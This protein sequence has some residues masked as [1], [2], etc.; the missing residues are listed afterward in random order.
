[1]FVP[2]RQRTYDWDE[3]KS[4]YELGHSAAECQAR[5]AI[6]NGAWY[7]AVQ[8]GAIVLRDTRHRPRTRT[9]V[10]IAA[11]LAEGLSQAAIA[12]ELGISR[13]T[14]C[15]HL[16]KLGIAAAVAPARRY[17][18]DEI[19]KYYEAGHSAADCRARFGFSRDA[20]RDAVVR[21]AIEPRPKLEPI[22]EVLAAGRRRSRAHI[23]ARLFMAGL[24]EGCCEG[25][26]LTE[27]QG[28]P[29]ALELHHV[30]GDGRDNR[31]SNLQLLC[32][33]CHS[34]TDTWGGRNKARRDPGR[35]DKREAA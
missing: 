31:L 30:N 35:G 33:N 29:V 7:G 22:D 21:G 12:R 11:L 18:W 23:K 17:D 27:W 26:G 14:V 28:A 25:C 15:F 6:T 5:F 24:K 8:R 13:P 20:W 32:P 16:R 2:R 10:L 19:R 34:Q 3:I 1:M 4:F 9:R